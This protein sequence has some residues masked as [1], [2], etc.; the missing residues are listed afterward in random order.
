MLH[1]RFFPHHLS[2]FK[3]LTVFSPSQNSEFRTITLPPQQARTQRMRLKNSFESERGR[4]R[5]AI[6]H[7]ATPAKVYTRMTFLSSVLTYI[8]TLESEIGRETENETVVPILP[9]STLVSPRNL[10]IP[11]IVPN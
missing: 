11:L 5:A 4:R 2:V 3:C 6:H 10:K 7:R 1:P 9:R 8:A